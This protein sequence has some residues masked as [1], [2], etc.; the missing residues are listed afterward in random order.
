MTAWNLVAFQKLL[1]N[2]NKPHSN[3][4]KSSLSSKY[5]TS[6]ISKS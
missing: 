2:S 6:S 3:N 5:R 1:L 4:K